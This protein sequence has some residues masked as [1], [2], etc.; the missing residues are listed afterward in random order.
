M[1]IRGP[2]A[3]PI[4]LPA[5]EL[6]LFHDKPAAKRRRR[7][8]SA[9]DD[10]ISFVES[11]PVTS[12]LLAGKKFKLPDWQRD[13][14]RRIYATDAAGRR[15]V[16]QALITMP[17]KNG[18]TGLSAALALAHLAGPMAE[19]RG[20]AYSAA[21]DRA[22]AALIFNEMKAIIRAVPDLAQRIIVRDFNKQLEDTV[23]GSIYVALSADVGTKH[24][25]SASFVVYD[26]LAQAP[27]RKLFDVLL[28]SM[29]GR[30]EPL[31]VVIS[32]QSPDPHSIM[33]ELTHYGEQVL[34]GVHEDPTFS[35]TIYAAPDDA[36]PWDEATWR[37]CNPALGDFRSLE[38]MQAAATQ[39]QRIPARESVFR[40]LYLNQRVEADSRFIPLADWQAC[41]ADIDIDALRGRPC[42]G[43]L[44][45]SSTQDLTALVL[46]FPEDGGAVLPFFW[47]PRDRLDEREHTDRVPYATWFKA[48]L[49]E[50]PQGR[51]IDRLAIIR[52]LAELASTYDIKGLAYDRWRLEDLKKLLSDEDIDVPITGWGQGFQSMG[53][54]V[55]LLETAI[56]NIELKH[57]NHPVLTWNVSNAVVEMDPAGARK[58][59]KSRSR[60]KVDG[61]VGLCMAIGLHAKEPA[62]REYD[63]SGPLVISA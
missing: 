19:P 55:D 46:Y 61:V 62:P 1:G 56:L 24:G 53:P 50:A 5:G 27:D 47:V 52:R 31:M 10:L 30:K 22:Q 39:A 26:E 9:L 15:V 32:T 58:I 4:R 17:R 6:S 59:S 35:A 33:S 63:F 14:L 54:A 16:R 49:I 23:T 40:L 13:I 48:G 7:G 28:S 25:F 2:G 11:L 38:E 43:G 45:L 41:G 29:G 8:K 12:G 42:W 18:K 21:A 36:D 37:A 20:Q 60:E 57:G 51:A 3:V 34:T 44:D